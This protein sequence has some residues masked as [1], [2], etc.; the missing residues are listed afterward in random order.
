MSSPIAHTSIAVTGYIIM[1][2][3]FGNKVR[4]PNLKTLTFLAILTTLPDFDFIIYIF[5]QDR[6]WHRG[7]THSLFFV[8]FMYI[9]SKLVFKNKRID[10]LKINTL[11]V[12]S[13]LAHIVPDLFV[14]DGKHETTQ[15]LLWPIQKRLKLN[16]YLVIFD[17]INY[18]SINDLISLNTLI[19]IFKEIM[20][21][22]I[23]LISTIIF[24]NIIRLLKINSE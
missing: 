2:T 9:I 15:M 7:F 10:G 13:I 1:S 12:M 14:G 17:P 24:Y 5:L 19:S 22:G 4:L 20:I 8:L 3:K 18:E 11:V 16:E 6:T 23:I 21:G